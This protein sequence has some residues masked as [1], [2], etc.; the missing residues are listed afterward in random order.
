MYEVLH[1]S[2]A[3]IAKEIGSKPASVCDVY[4]HKLRGQKYL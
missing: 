4:N 2:Y 3:K 1:Y